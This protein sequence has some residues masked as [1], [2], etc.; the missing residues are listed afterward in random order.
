VVLQVFFILIV[1][2]TLFILEGPSTFGMTPDSV[3]IGYHTSVNSRVIDIQ[4]TDL[5]DFIKK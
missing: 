1:F 3:T 5:G 4:I 2:F